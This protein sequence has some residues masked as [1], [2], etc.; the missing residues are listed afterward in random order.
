MFSPTKMQI[1]SIN[2]N[3]QTNKKLQNG[4]SQCR[5]R[6]GIDTITESGYYK[7]VYN[8][9]FLVAFINAF[10]VNQKSMLRIL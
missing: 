1:V 6:S 10:F 5:D 8:H 3:E 4:H 2:Q 9:S 7:T